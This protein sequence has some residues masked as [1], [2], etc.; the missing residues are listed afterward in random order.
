MCSATI[1]VHRLNLQSSGLRQT[2]S[3][4]WVTPV[5][6]GVRASRWASTRCA[7][8]RGRR[9]AVPCSVWWS[10]LRKAFPRVVLPLSACPAADGHP[11]CGPALAV[12]GGKVWAGTC[13]EG[14]A[15]P[16]GLVVRRL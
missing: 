2:Q 12:V 3:P 9:L 6:I 8:S 10:F 13:L 1:F 7:L 5:P 15:G 4:S 16:G 14:E 11:G